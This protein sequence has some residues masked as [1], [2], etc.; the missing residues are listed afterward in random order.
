[1]LFSSSFAALA[2]VS[3]V[4][5]SP[6][7]KRQGPGTGLPTNATRPDTSSGNVTYTPVSSTEQVGSSYLNATVESV[8]LGVNTTG[9]WTVPY[10]N[11]SEPYPGAHIFI[12]N[13]VTNGTNNSL[14]WPGQPTG[15]QLIYKPTYQVESNFDFQ[16]L[17]LAL[18]Q[19]LIELDLFHNGLARFTVEEFEAAGLNADDRF[20]IE[21]MANQ[22]V[23]H[24]IALTNM[25]GGDRAAKQC[26]Y[27]YPFNTVKE[28]VAF[29]QLLTR[30]G[31]AGVYG[32]LGQLDSRPAAQI[33]LQSITTEARQQMVFRQFQGL[34][35]QPE[36]FETGLP[37]SYAWTLLSPYIKSCPPNNPRIEWTRFPLI[38]I[39]NQPYALDG[40]PGIN[41]NYTLTEGAGREITF[42]W[43]PLNKTVGYDDLYKT[44]SVAGDPKF[45]AFISQYNVTYV[46]LQNVSNNSAS[47][48][49]PNATV[50]PGIG[51]SQITNSVFV[52]LTD[53]D[54]YV[55][56]Y[57]LTLINNATVAVGIYQAS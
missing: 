47:A 34:P 25:L 38:N 19:E 11:G 50:F 26:V 4:H 7:V 1:M 21:H 24:A 43:E 45:M 51:P 3:A 8:P 9:N 40:I 14:A 15:G 10:T 41:S 12:G 27:Q 28:F 2:A 29:N 39:T 33:L 44:S 35:A 37:Q 23:G 32:F 42:E 48:I 57:N 16:S 17:N 5:A 54:I 31:E 20:L 22:E 18:N 55:T 46:P 36:W 6:V 52:A 49:V 56:P 53:S 13:P 30:W